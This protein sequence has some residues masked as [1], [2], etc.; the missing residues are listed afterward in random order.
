MQKLTYGKTD[1]NLRLLREQKGLSRE[2]LARHAGVSTSTV[3]RMELLG[4]IPSG[5]ALIAIAKELGVS[6]DLIVGYEPPSAFPAAT[7]STDVA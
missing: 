7:N 6:I 5:Y 3:T 4:H 1:A 2:K